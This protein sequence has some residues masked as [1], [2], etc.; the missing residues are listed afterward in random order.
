[1]LRF[2]FRRALNGDGF[3]D[4]YFTDYDLGS[5][6]GS[7]SCGDPENDFNDK[8]LLN[9]GYAAPGFFADETGDQLFGMVSGLNMGFEMSSF[10]AASAIA[11]MDGDAKNDIVKQTALYFP[12]Y[13]GVAYNDSA[14]E[15]FYD[16]YQVVNDLSPYWDSVGD[17]NNDD[18]A[19][20]VL[21]D[22]GADRYYLNQGVVSDGVPSFLAFVFSF[23][24]SGPGGAASDDGFGGNSLVA[25]LDGDG[26]NDVLIAD[27][28]HD[29]QGCTRRMKIYRNVGGFP[30]DNVTLREETA[31]TSCQTFQGNPASCTVAGIPTNELEGVHDVAVFDLDGDGRNDM[32]VGRC[33][34][35]AVY[36]NVPPPDGVGGIPDGR[37]VEG[38]PLTIDRVGAGDVTLSWEPSC[39]T[40]AGDYEVYEGA[41]GDWY[42]HLRRFCSTGGATVQTLTPV[43][44]DRYFLVVPTDGVV[45]GSY[46]RNSA[47]AARP[48]GATTCRP[49]NIGSCSN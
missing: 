42:S 5:G 1:V 21:T 49:I 12:T 44:G 14:E 24:H 46:G 37:F 7:E 6:S 20:I 30:G 3:A 41:I 2:G 48:V 18:L 15:G 11:D 47:G 27:V 32:V 45:E 34:G 36:R 28:N 33:T 43:A 23:V 40:G 16:A 35:T 31:G 19:D 22:D 38:A 17:L 39:S 9:S 4:L 25:D 13:V 10:G 26:W 8:L 29:I